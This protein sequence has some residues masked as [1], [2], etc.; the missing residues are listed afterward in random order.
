MLATVFKS[1]YEFYVHIKSAPLEILKAFNIY[2][3]P[4]QILEWTHKWVQLLATKN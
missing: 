2:L 1:V 4:F 3:V